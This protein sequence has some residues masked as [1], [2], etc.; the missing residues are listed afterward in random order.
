[1]AYVYSNNKIGE[2]VGLE[3]SHL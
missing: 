1:M 3:H 2:A